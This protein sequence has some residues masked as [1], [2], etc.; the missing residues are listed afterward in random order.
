MDLSGEALAM[1]GV[2]AQRRQLRETGET[3]IVREPI[4]DASHAIAFD[5]SPG[6][7][8]PDLSMTVPAGYFF[9]MGDHRLRANDSR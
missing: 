6:A 2:P 5:H 7:L 1:D 9:V 4:G 3:T 8:P